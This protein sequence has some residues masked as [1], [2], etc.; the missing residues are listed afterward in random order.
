V[1][2]VRVKM[3]GLFSLTKR[4]YLGQAVSGAIGA[5]IVFGGWFFAWPPMLKGLTRP[6]LPPSAFREMIVVVLN[7]VPWILLA[8]LVYKAI[9]VYI[10]LRIFGRKEAAAK[11]PGAGQVT[12]TSPG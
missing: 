8:A 2:P 9:E 11:T 7:N 12:T 10:V 6:E 3:Y 5:A 4:R 1:E